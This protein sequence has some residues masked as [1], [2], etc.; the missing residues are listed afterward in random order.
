MM[1]NDR[2]KK[3][4]SKINKFNFKSNWKVY[5]VIQKQ[6]EAEI[7]LELYHDII[8]VAFIYYFGTFRPPQFRENSSWCK[9]EGV[10]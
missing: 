9:A 2:N 8:L 6:T 4:L 5:M 10:G 7:A 1:K 3:D